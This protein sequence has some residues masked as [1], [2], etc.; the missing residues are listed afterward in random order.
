MLQ[1]IPPVNYKVH[2]FTL[3]IIVLANIMTPLGCDRKFVSL[4]I[5][6]SL[7]L[8]NLVKPTAFSIYNAFYKA[9]G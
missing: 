8:T 6:F 2:L 1:P 7:F 9:F 3:S 5:S 4:I